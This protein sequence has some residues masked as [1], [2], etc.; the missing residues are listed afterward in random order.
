ML[1]FNSFPK[2]ITTDYNNNLIA[3]TNIINC[4]I[5]YNVKRLVFTSTMAV[6]GENMIPFD[7]EEGNNIVAICR[8]FK[9]AILPKLNLSDSIARL[10]FPPIWDI[11]FQGIS[12]MGVETP[13]LYQQ[14]ALINVGVDYGSGATSVLTFHDGNPVQVKLSLTFQ[15]IRKQR[16]M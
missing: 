11:S 12:G 15:S 13:S 1:Y 9:K 8:N 7:E 10:H 16:L 6:Y 3:T 4:C 14:M 2:I 5:N